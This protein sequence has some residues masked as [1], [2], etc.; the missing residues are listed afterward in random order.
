PCL[1]ASHGGRVVAGGLTRRSGGGWWL[2]AAVGRWLVASRGVLRRL[3]ASR[4]VLRRLAA[5]LA[6]AQCSLG[7]R[8]VVGGRAS[9]SKKRRNHDGCGAFAG[10]GGQ[11]PSRGVHSAAPVGVG[12]VK[13]SGV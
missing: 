3:V 5:S 2:H 6:A 10:P 1:V 8:G 13:R 4:G 11:I 12:R 7:D 9:G